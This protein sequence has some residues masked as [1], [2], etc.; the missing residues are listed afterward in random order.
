[1][2]LEYAE[3]VLPAAVLVHETY[4]PGAVNRVTAFKLD[5]EEVEVWKGK[6]PTATDAGKGV[7]EIAADVRFKTN[8]IKIYLDSKAVPGWNEIDAVGLRD[9]AGKTHWAVSAEASS[10]YAQVGPLGVIVVAPV[11]GPGFVLPP[12]LPPPVPIPPPF[13]VPPPAP[14]VLVPVPLPTPPAV[15][16]KDKRIKDLEQEVKELKEKLKALEEKKEG[17]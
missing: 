9:T 15:D 3:P 8:R 1:L 11:P 4:N 2:L 17:R 6:D 16:E 13:T 12:P 5:G 10:T 14:P 7:S